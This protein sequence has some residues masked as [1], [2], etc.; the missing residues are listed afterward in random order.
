ME[1]SETG[2]RNSAPALLIKTSRLDSLL[3]QAAIEESDRTSSVSVLMP[4]EASLVI[5]ER[6]RAVV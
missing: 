4:R 5:F 6:F 1:T 3:T 2:I